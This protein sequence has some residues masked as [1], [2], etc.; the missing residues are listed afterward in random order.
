M[1]VLL[2]VIPPNNKRGSWVVAGNQI[3]HTR[4]DETQVT[5]YVAD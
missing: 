1:E 3:H 4:G 2:G 5:I